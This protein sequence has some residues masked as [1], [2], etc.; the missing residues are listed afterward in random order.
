ML[1]TSKVNRRKEGNVHDSAMGKLSPTLEDYL[2]AIWRLEHEKGFARVRDIADAMGVA[3]STGTAALQAL[4]EKGL[5]NYKPYEPVTLSAKGREKSDR[6]V[7]RHRIVEDFLV[8]VLDIASER[9]GPIA[10]GMEHAVDRETLERFVCFLAFI[11]QHAPGGIDWLGQFRQF[12][13][14]GA[15]G[16]TCRECVEAYMEQLQQ[17]SPGNA[18]QDATEN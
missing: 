14:E 3:S 8:N 6:I 12:I 7:L 15:D 9:A 2:E 4:H 10:C 17:P 11:K 13:K 1:E 18:E 5:I 16:Q